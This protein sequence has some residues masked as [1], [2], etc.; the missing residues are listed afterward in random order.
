MYSNVWNTNLLDIN[1]TQITGVS[2][3]CYNATQKQCDK[4]PNI[5]ACNLKLTKE[6]H[7]KVIAL[8]RDLSKIHDPGDKFFLCYDDECIGV[9]YWDRMNKR[10]KKK[11]DLLMYGGCKEFGIKSGILIKRKM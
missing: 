8:S 2:I 6:H 11:V 1:K 3:T 9:E 10:F 7:K 4:T 5:T